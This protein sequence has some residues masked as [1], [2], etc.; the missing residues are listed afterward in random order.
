MLFGRLEMSDSTKSSHE[1]DDPEL[2][3]GRLVTMSTHSP[4]Q[5]DRFQVLIQG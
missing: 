3:I 5:P 2:R 4:N 1:S